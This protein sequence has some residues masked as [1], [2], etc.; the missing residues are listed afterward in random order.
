MVS[1]IIS[2]WQSGPSSSSSTLIVQQPHP[3]QGQGQLLLL[4]QQTMPPTSVPS[5][6]LPPIMPMDTHILTDTDTDTD[7][8]TETETDIEI[9]AARNTTDGLRRDN[10]QPEDMIANANRLSL[11]SSLDSLNNLSNGSGVAVVQGLPRATLSP[12]K[13]LLLTRTHHP[14]YPFSTS[15]THPLHWFLPSRSPIQ[16]HE[17]ISKMALSYLAPTSRAMSPH[18]VLSVDE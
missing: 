2:F 18:S 4:Q 9:D 14:H 5:H 8:F 10:L 11:L 1:D 15:A 3:T 17:Q 16:F 12:A 6:S 7:V 13:A